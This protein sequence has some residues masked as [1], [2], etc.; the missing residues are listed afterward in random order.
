MTIN[1]I[2]AFIICLAIPLGTG[3]LSGYLTMEETRTWFQAI[4]KPS[5]TPPDQVFGPVWIILYT[6]M[7]VSLYMIWDT[8]R[9]WL[10]RK[11]MLVFALQL[12]FNFWWSLIFFSFHLLFAAVIDI[13]ILW[14][15][16]L[17]MI[18]CFKE[19]KPL[20]AWL[21]VPY[22]LWVSFATALT[23]SVWALN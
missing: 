6:L 1:K 14:L 7:G 11:A 20:A 17:Y 3:L 21:N 13:L 10:R 8:R 18:R 4:N 12:F 16:I 15:L 2:I 23:V 22:L 19:V 5:F 9:N